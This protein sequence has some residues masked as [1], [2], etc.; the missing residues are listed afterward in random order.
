MTQATP[1]PTLLR[2][3]LRLGWRYFKWLT[4]V[5]V[6]VPLTL[7]ILAALLLGTPLGARVSVSLANALVPGLTL[8]YSSGT[9]NKHLSLANAGWSGTG[10]DVRLTNVDFAW[11]PACL[12]HRQVCVNDLSATE[13]KVAIDTQALAAATTLETNLEADRDDGPAALPLAISLAQAELHQVRVT[14]DSNSFSAASLHTG[15][16]WRAEGLIVTSLDTQ[17]LEV[18]IPADPIQGQASVPGQVPTAATAGI[19]TSIPAGIHANRDASTANV[20]PLAQLPAVGM[21]FPLYV[22]ALTLTDSRLQLGTRVDH[23][24]HIAL[25]ASYLGYDLVINELN[26]SHDDGTVQLSGEL[27]LEGAYPLRLKAALALDKLAELPQ[28]TGQTL[29][30]TL[31]NDLHDLHLSAS[32]QGDAGFSLRGKINLQSPDLPYQ[33]SLAQGMAHWP[34]QAPLYTLSELTLQSQGNLRQQ[35]SSLTARLG[36]P[37]HGELAIATE[38][39]HGDEKLTLERF[40]AKGSPG[41]LSL[42][43]EL[44]YSD[45]LRWQTRLMTQELQLEQ[46]LLPDGQTLPESSISG[47]L[48]SQ[49]YWQD[50]HWQVALSQTQLQGSLR[51]FPFTLDGDVRLD[52]LWHLSAQ[53]LHAEALG[54]SLTMHGT[55]GQQWDLHGQLNVPDFSRWL[56][57]AKGRLRAQLDVSGSESHPQLQLAADIGE[58]EYAG[59]NLQAAKL[60]G[61]Y[62]P[63]DNH[64]FDIELKTRDLVWNGH[65]LTGSSIVAKGD[66]R[67]QTL[68]LNTQGE[69]ALASHIASQFDAEHSLWAISVA[70]L[71]LGTRLGRWQLDKRV[72]IAWDQARAQGKLSAFCLQHAEGR[73]C[74]TDANHIGNLGKV[75]LEGQGNP[76]K[77]LA[78]LLPA[79]IDW[80]GPARLEAELDWAPQHKPKA[81]LALEFAPG[82]LTLQQDKQRRLKMNYQQ[83]SLL[84][85]LDERQLV[86]QIQFQSEDIASLDTEIAVSVTP[87]RRLSG[88]AN[89]Q[90]INLAPFGEF[91]PQLDRLE[92]LL[93]SKLTF[94]GDLMTPRVAGEI[95]LKQGTLSLASNPTLL[96]NID[97]DMR[98]AGQQ[99]RLAGHWQM[100]DGKGQLSG[101]LQWPQ[102]QFSGE[103]A[104]QG[105]ELALIQPPLAILDVSPDITVRFDRRLLDISGKISVPS[106]NIKIV[107]LVKGGVAVSDDVIFDD[108]I[109][110][111]Q[112][113]LSPYGIAANLNIEVGKALLIDGMGLKGK[114]RGSLKLQQQAFRPPLLY[115]DVR[116]VNGSYRFM[117]QTLKITKGEVQFVGPTQVPNLNIEAIREI[118]T[119][120]ITA[121]VRITGT[122]QR[123]LVTLFSN[124]AKEQGEILSYILKG[125]GLSS[126]TSEQNN[127]LMISAAL[128]LS[129]QLDGGAIGGIGSTATGLIEKFGFSNVQLDTNDEGRVAISGFIGEDLM[130]KYGI[131]VFNPGYE[132]TVRYYLLSQLYLETVSGTLGQS[133]DIYYSFDL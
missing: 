74:L 97:M 81:Y 114:L 46:L 63:L 79:H 41:M 110:A 132:M 27:A 123:P 35:H 14:V 45:G 47:R 121:G 50:G 66:A 34:L 107:P 21:P 115:G 133:L 76:G 105:R 2:A 82:S 6:Y 86:N 59:A 130:V 92:G 8:S 65:S 73:L 15:A 120:D 62:S 125:K 23:F 113:Q 24:G 67:A 91:F 72:D 128:S 49:G 106:G 51:H 118:R 101:Q 109:A 29:Q 7:V 93:S 127:A 80:D 39:S 60:N 129:S 48:N 25:S 61:L 88:F 75:K 55:A 17:G 28:L 83:L 69:L 131:G 117:G 5:L 68:T 95:G 126:S 53:A 84:S 57:T 10:I 19:P 78:P 13:V 90:E 12:L 32:A 16:T 30:L 85:R 64:K 96:E 94:A 119:E 124:P 31:D 37:F 42:Q 22:K 104:I 3:R 89:I 33:M 9:L 98:L 70:D 99:G 26:A 108:S 87:D 36:T 52:N 43:G 100:G 58:A 112:Q 1:A 20:W 54:A 40:D 103:L 4:R 44:D 18:V 102:G 38:F 56:P 111:E 116:V 77:I 11:T 122:P 71:S